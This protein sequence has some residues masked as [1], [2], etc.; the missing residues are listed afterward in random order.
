MK[1]MNMATMATKRELK[2][3]RSFIGKFLLKS[4]ICFREVSKARNMMSAVA[5]K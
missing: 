4:S 1:E 3:I 5:E 2:P